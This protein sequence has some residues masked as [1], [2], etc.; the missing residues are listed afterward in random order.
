MTKKELIQMI[1]EI[2]DCYQLD[3]PVG[4]EIRKNGKDAKAELGVMIR[5]KFMP[6]V[7]HE[8]SEACQHAGQCMHFEQ[9]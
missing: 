1:E 7:L 2:P 9:A 8:G 6:L 4:F 5:G 3:F